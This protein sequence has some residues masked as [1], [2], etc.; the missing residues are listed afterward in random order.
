MVESPYPVYPA[1]PAYHGRFAPSPTGPLHFG[2]LI[3]ATASYLQAKSQQ[4]SWQV[5]IDDLDEARCVP[6][7]ADDILRTLQQYGF[8][9]DQAPVYQSQRQAA[10]RQALQQLQA[11][12]VVYP[13]SC[14]RREIADATS[15]AA[16]VAVYPGT[17]RNGISKPTDQIRHISYRVRTTGD[18]TCFVD[19]IQGKQR[20]ILQQQVGDFVLCRADEQFT[21]QLAVV[22]DDAWQNITEVVRGC[23]LLASTARQVYLQQL[24]GLPTP[25]YRHHP[26]ITNTQGQKLSKQTH[27]RPLSGASPVG[28]LWQVLSFL[29]QRP[30]DELRD[31]PLCTFWQW[32]IAHWQGAKIPAKSE[33][34]TEIYYN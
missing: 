1:Y 17:C 31:Q 32:A 13:C 27:A 28:A 9:W 16:E 34:F 20:Q 33:L 24:L 23:D 18:E 25:G 2:S 3:A 4:G 22:V 7:A 19:E 5:R 26:V 30:P 14:S 10:Y 11:L 29:N 21:Y 12:D 6:G 8:E 15:S